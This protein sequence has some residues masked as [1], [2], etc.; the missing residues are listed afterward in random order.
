MEDGQREEEEEERQEDTEDPYPPAWT[1][2]WPNAAS[3]I[4]LDKYEELKDCFADP[5]YK[6]KNLWNSI[7]KSLDEAG[8]TYTSNQVAARWRT[9]LQAYVRAKNASKSGRG[10]KR[11]PYQKEL[12]RLI[13]SDPSILP[14]PTSAKWTARNSFDILDPS[15]IPQPSTQLSWIPQASA[16]FG[17]GSASPSAS[18]PAKRD[19]TGSRTVEDKVMRYLVECEKRKAQR[20]KEKLQMAWEMHRE[21]MD[22]MRTLLKR[23]GDHS[24]S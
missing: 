5:K 9:M 20:H 1:H 21:R 4:L 24:Y 17:N 19:M 12:D 2:Q 23:N 13:D 11:C 7:R 3:L 14:N 15:T 22:L 18:N 6:K 16:G 10:R 8:Y